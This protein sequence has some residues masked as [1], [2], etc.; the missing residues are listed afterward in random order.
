MEFKKL[1]IM[2]AIEQFNYSGI[3]YSFEN[4][5]KQIVLSQIENYDEPK[6]FFE[7]LFQGGCISGLIS[8]FIYTSDCKDFYIKH[9]DDMENMVEE[10]S[11]ILG[12]PVSNRHNLPRY[13]FMCH[14]CFEEYCLS[15]YNEIYES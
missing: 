4:E 3:P 13:S 9:M 12:E 8:E 11:Y 15:M 7:D 6:N 1:E 5:F 14:L 2:R 10:I